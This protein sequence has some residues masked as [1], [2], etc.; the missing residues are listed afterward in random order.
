[1]PPFI[2]NNTSGTVTDIGSYALAQ[3]SVPKRY[4][5]FLWL[6]TRG[7]K[8]NDFKDISLPYGKLSVRKDDDGIY[9]GK[10]IKEGV[11]DSAEIPVEFEKK[12]IPEI[13]T[14]LSAKEI[15]EPEVAEAK[16]EEQP[17]LPESEG[18]EE[19]E[20]SEEVEEIEEEPSEK[21]VEA[22]S[23][24]NI[25]ITINV[26]KS[27]KGVTMSDHK[28]EKNTGLIA[29]ELMKKL[30][31]AGY[32][33]SQI[34]GAKTLKDLIK[35]LS[36]DEQ[37]E[38]M[39]QLAGQ[40]KEAQKNFS[41]YKKELD[42]PE[43]LESDEKVKKAKAGF[44]KMIHQ[45]QKTENKEAASRRAFSILKSHYGIE[46]MKK[47]K[48]SLKKSSDRWHDTLGELFPD[49]FS[50]VKIK[51]NKL[52]DTM[53]EMRKGGFVDPKQFAKPGNSYLFK[54]KIYET[55]REEP[56]KVEVEKGK[57]A[58]K[59]AVDSWIAKT[60]NVDVMPIYK[61][62]LVDESPSPD[63]N[64]SLSADNQGDIDQLKHDNEGPES[65]SEQ[66]TPVMEPEGSEHMAS[67][68]G[69]NEQLQ[70]FADRLNSLAQT[71]WDNPESSGEMKPEK[72]EENLGGN[73]DIE[74][75]QKK[76]TPEASPESAIN[77]WENE[78]I[79]GQGSGTMGKDG[80]AGKMD[81]MKE[82]KEIE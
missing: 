22:L 14:I 45:F 62:Q 8:V 74:D 57:E 75:V 13:V 71:T 63:N 5:L 20:E 37:K 48:Q 69:G 78:D 42:M 16:A 4:L 43:D 54:M 33:T 55:D 68:N 36:E 46:G 47:I 3:L 2:L 52:D 10:Y 79:D 70:E 25:N 49:V 1:M 41:E 82:K 60:K 27:K 6:Q 38:L 19:L 64:E 9:S 31:K 35:D 56:A 7:L 17:I 44:Q 26:H 66:Q 53:P 18:P 80:L 11:S 34:Q 24:S 21:A 15:I 73:G 23:G 40:K 50:R 77:A 76:D 51:S 29:G 61:A 30:R 81:D 39:E 65:P 59:K 72:S 58:I 12:T 32:S 28:F 67:A